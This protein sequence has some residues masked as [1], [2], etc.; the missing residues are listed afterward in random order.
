[1]K[2]NNE[3][4]LIPD[5]T[6]YR[7]IF[8]AAPEAYFIFFGDVIADCNKVACEILRGT[9]EQIIGATVQSISPPFQPDGQRS[10]SASKSMLEKATINGKTKFNWIHRRFDRTD[11]PVA[12]SVSSFELLNKK[13]FLVNWHDLSEHIKCEK[14]LREERDRLS[15]YIE[16]S[17]IG[18]WQWNIQTDELTVNERWTE[19]LGYTLDELAPIS[20]QTRNEFV[21]PDDLKKSYDLLLLHFSKS[22]EYFDAECR[23]KHKNGSWIWVHNRGKVTE[24]DTDGKPLIMTGT[25]SDVSQRKCAEERLRESEENLRSIFENVNVG[26]VVID[27]Q[28]MIIEQLNTYAAQ[29]INAAPESIIGK[30]CHGIICPAPEGQCSIVDNKASVEH[31]DCILLTADAIEIPVIKTARNIHIKGKDMLLESFVDI[32]LRKKIE[33]ALIATNRQLEFTTKQANEMAAQAEKATS[34]KSEFI[35][36]M[37]HEIR[38]PMNGVIGMT[39]LLLDTVLTNEQREYAEIVR[40]SS[41]SLLELINGIL[42][43]SKI[44]AKKLD[45]EFIDFDLQSLLIDF[46]A[47]QAYKAHEKGLELSWKIDND[48][49][50]LLRGDPGR[51]RQILGN[52]T[53]NALKFTEKG[54]V[55]IHISLINTLADTGTLNKTD[56][57]SV[58]LR[59]SVTDTGIG[60]PADKINLLFNKFTQ[61]DASATR[62]YGGTGLGLAISRQL[63]QMMG[64]DIGV[65][66]Q[67]GAGSEFWF[68]I[69]LEKQDNPVAAEN[70]IQEIPA[71][72]SILIVVNN[73]VDLKILNSRLQSWELN[74]ASVNNGTVVPVTLKDA[75]EKGSPFDVIIID[76]QLPD[77]SCETL[78]QTI[79]TNSLFANLQLILLTTHGNRG[80]A[81]RFSGIGFDGYLT[82]PIRHEEFKK[83]LSALLNNNRSCKNLKKTIIT[84]HSL[85][86]S[87]RLTSNT[88]ARILLVEDNIINQKVADSILRTLGFTAD[89]VNDGTKAIDALRTTSYDLV[90]MDIQMDG[91]DGLEAT[92]KIRDPATAVLNCNVPIVA[93]T[94]QAMN[95]DREKCLETGMNDYIS[96]PISH[97]NL[98][99]MLNKWLPSTQPQQTSE[100]SM[101]QSDAVSADIFNEDYQADIWDLSSMLDNI[102]NDEEQTKTMITDFL[103]HIPAHIDSIETTLQSYDWHAAEL[104]AHTIM[105]ASATIG[106]Q[107]LKVLAMSLENELHANEPV[108]AKATFISLKKCFNELHVLME[109]ELA[110]LD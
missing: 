54:S 87:I 6:A 95:G 34:A 18:T 14:E 44:E 3:T 60:I 58:T 94:A 8:D 62:K 31:E 85:R 53:S 27:P 55:S 70:I 107:R 99:T 97:E 15:K 5:D 109:K 98:I 9:R 89:I 4:P 57:T 110:A 23:M 75:I 78:A 100:P 16:S 50:P 59:I 108:S 40:S 92:K 41:E 80:D 25:Q 63:S 90:F 36:N 28:T 64:G 71:N 106:A 49:P 47:L 48:V 11:F 26:I 84:R 38:T 93:M 12:V 21:H 82:K 32:R 86:E 66:S 81:K 20:I 2:N 103:N 91:M 105:G 24:W 88:K 52:L 43:F 46:L 29:L 30:R 65:N 56:N 13:A 1:M 22:I 7:A 39:S 45:L 51:I 102:I 35:A 69:K 104:H 76:T 101:E 77:M 33:A 79:K 17:R 96:K 61:I 73:D 74:V 83:M 72:S 68:T 10:D 42:D 37:S 67:D 19:I